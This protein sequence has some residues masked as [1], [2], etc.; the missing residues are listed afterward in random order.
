MDEKLYIC[1]ICEKEYNSYMGLWKHKKIK[2]TEN[3]TIVKKEIINLSM[4]Y[5]VI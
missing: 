1:L 2:H 5:F 3:E 4:D